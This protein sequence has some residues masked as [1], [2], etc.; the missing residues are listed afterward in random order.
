MCPLAR[1]LCISRHPRLGLPVARGCVEAAVGAF[2]PPPFFFRFSWLRGGVCGRGSWPCR[3]V[4]L[5]WSPSP[6]L[7][8]ASLVSAPSF[9]FLCFFCVFAVSTCLWPV[10]RHFCGGVCA[11]MSGVSSPPA[12]LR[13]YGRGGP[14]FLAGRFQAGRG[15]PPVSYQQALWV[16]PLVLPGWGIACLFGVSARLCGC[17][18]VRPVFLLSHSPAGV[19]SWMGG[20]SPLLCFFLGAG[21][22]VP[23]SAL[24][25]LVHALVSNQGG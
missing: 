14:L 10:A 21:L 12:L 4:A 24:P 9:G 16:S 1:A 20:A 22:P 19:R 15:G 7:V 11:G 2:L 25:G 18:T 17:A 23:P 8:L 6:V 5:W 3:V 13:L